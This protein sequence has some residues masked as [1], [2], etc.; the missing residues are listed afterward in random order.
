MRFRLSAILVTGWLVAC[1]GDEAGGG[2]EDSL[3]L[4]TDADTGDGS[5]TGDWTDD[6]SASASSGLTEG[7]SGTTS[8]GSESDGGD[9]DGDSGDGPCGDGKRNRGEQCDLN[10]FGGER[11]EDFETGAGL[12]FTGGDLG[13][14]VQCNRDLSGC[15][16]CGDGVRQA[17]EVCDGDDLGPTT[18]EML[19]FSGGELACDTACNAFDTTLCSICGN[20]DLELGETCDDGNTDDSDACPSTCQP[21]ACGDGHVQA[22]VESCDDG[23]LVPGDGCDDTCMVETTVG[24][25]YPEAG[26]NWNDYV[27]NDGVDPQNASGAPC[28]GNEGGGHGIGCLHAGELRVVELPELSSCAGLSALDALGGFDWTCDDSDGSVR[29]ISTGLSAGKHLSDLIDFGTPAFL[30]NEV[31]V[32]DGL[33]LVAQTAST[34]WWDNPVVAESNAGIA[35]VEGTIYAISSDPGTQQDIRADR[36]GWVAAPGVTL[37]G[38]DALAVLTLTGNRHFLWIEGSFNGQGEAQGSIYGSNSLGYSV[39]DNVHTQ[40]GP[41]GVHLGALV[42]S[43][44]FRDVVSRGGTSHGFWLVNGLGNR[45]ERVET[46]N[47]DGDGLRLDGGVQNILVDVRAG[48]NRYGLYLAGPSAQNQVHGY[49]ASGNAN[50]IRLDENVSGNAF[51][52]VAVFNSQDF[53]IRLE[54]GA[55][56]NVFTHMVVASAADDGLL[57]APTAS[58]NAFLG[59]TIANQGGRGM[60][61]D[62]LSDRNLFMNVAVYNTGSDGILLDSSANNRFHDVAVAHTGGDC[63][64]L[65]SSFNNRFSGT[66]RVAYADPAESLCQ[67]DLTSGDLMD[68]ACLA[69]GQS[70]HVLVIGSSMSASFVGEVTTT[71]TVNTSNVAGTSPASNMTDL[72]GFERKWRGWGRD[73]LTMDSWWGDCSSGTCRIWDFGLLAQDGVLRNMATPPDGDDTL[74]HV[75]AS[76]ATTMLRNAAEILADGQGD[77]DGLCE[78]NERC[79]FLPNAGAYQGHGELVSMPVPDGTLVGIELFH[80]E[81]NGH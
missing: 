78:S 68:L 1:S 41:H 15:F 45:F 7:A 25:L 53:G 8:G 63:I 4:G 50:G 19:G 33:S 47:F 62:V 6:P 51:S 73:G 27:A 38:S 10:D 23:N 65:A 29:F 72:F 42:T 81:F 70:D 30:P 54:D 55:A 56:Q 49:H 20:G 3:P 58:N 66:L 46:T 36:V 14:T 22:G 12:P 48:N 80:H 77:E 35:D 28:M 79:I 17:V 18:C 13:C 34:V 37:N 21:A 64:E 59:L 44:L 9:G 52:E 5:G 71:D 39:L 24:P 40:D 11:C 75:F 26:R 76:G 16:R 67:V 74:T 32:F 31:A 61:V 69:V 2:G 57:L 43:N 60:D